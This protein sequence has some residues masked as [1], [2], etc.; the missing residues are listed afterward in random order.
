MYLS[1]DLS[2]SDVKFSMAGGCDASLRDEVLIYRG[3]TWF[4]E[5]PKTLRQALRHGESDVANMKKTAY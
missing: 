5:P 2:K 1:T 3:P 4:L